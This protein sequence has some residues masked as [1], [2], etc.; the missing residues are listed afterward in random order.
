MLGR[1]LPK[2]TDFFQ[3]FNQM[4]E[5]AV[6]AA[7]TNVTLIGDLEHSERHSSKIKSLEQHAD[8]ITHLTVDMLHATF[9]T[10]IDRE[11][12]FNL[13][14]KLDDIIDTIDGAAARLTLYEIRNVPKQMADLT[15][16]MAEAVVCVSKAVACL[17]DLNDRD[18]LMKIINDIHHLEN[19]ADRMLND[20]VGKLF[21]DE[22]DIKQLIKLKEIFEIIEAVTD[23]CED[24]S[25]VIEAIMVEHS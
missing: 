6:E 2:Q 13:A 17:K 25:D 22:S 20:A 14:E 12:I 4:T 3:F 18:T 16:V 5:L 15:D 11:D 23:R 8:E 9:I 10:P 1:F 21:R 24:V 19:V 7:K